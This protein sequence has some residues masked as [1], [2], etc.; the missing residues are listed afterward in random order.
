MKKTIIAGL[1]SLGAMNTAA[2]Q[3]QE[4]TYGADPTGRSPGSYVG[5]TETGITVLGIESGNTTNVNFIDTNADVT[6]EDALAKSEEFF[7]GFPWPNGYQA[8]LLANYP[9]LPDDADRFEHLGVTSTMEAGEFKKLADALIATVKSIIKGTTYL[10]DS[11]EASGYRAVSVGGNQV[12][13]ANGTQFD[14]TT[15]YSCDF[16]QWDTS[17]GFLDNLNTCPSSEF[18]PLNVRG[19]SA[20]DIGLVT[21]ASNSRGT[22]V[23]KAKR[24]ESDTNFNEVVVFNAESKTFNNYPINRS[25]VRNGSKIQI[26]DGQKQFVVINHPEQSSGGFYWIDEGINPVEFRGDSNG[27]KVLSIDDDYINMISEN[28]ELFTCENNIQD[29]S[30]FTYH[31]IVRLELDPNEPGYEFYAAYPSLPAGLDGHIENLGIQDQL[32]LGSGL[33]EYKAFIEQHIL[34][35]VER[36]LQEYRDNKMIFVS[37]GENT[38][39]KIASDVSGVV[40]TFTSGG[41]QY[42]VYVKN[43][44]KPGEDITT[45]NQAVAIAYNHTTESSLSLSYQMMKELEN[46]DFSSLI[47]V[48]KQSNQSAYGSLINT[49]PNMPDNF[50]DYGLGPDISKEEYLSFV[51]NVVTNSLPYKASGSVDMYR[52]PLAFKFNGGKLGFNAGFL[53]LSETSENSVTVTGKPA[54]AVIDPYT[55]AVSSMDII[56]DGELFAADV[57]CSVTGPLDITS[58]EYGSWG[59]SERLTLPV[60]WQNKNASGVVSL[61]GDIDSVTGEQQLLVLDTLAELTTADVTVNCSATV[62]DKNG[63]QLSVNLVPVTIRLDDGIHGGS[64]V[65]TGQVTL[66]A[67]VNAEDVTVEVTI[68]GRTINVEV[69]ENGRFEFD[70]LRDGDFT[71]NVKSERYTQSCINTT[72]GGNTIDLGNIEL[73]A[74][75]VNNDGEINIA[76]FTYLAGRYGSAKG[77]ERY[78]VQADLNSD[79]KVNIQDLAILGSHFGSRQC[80]P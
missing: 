25:F 56:T 44:T 40:E 80:N 23:L 37:C 62:S 48:A 46:S 43:V 55:N 67:G 47:E 4:L 31:D 72:T 13:I 8:G 12:L 64:G 68:N 52:L 65:I 42:T 69:D 7:R 17:K 73:I 10:Y 66:P 28:K 2:L 20:F 79:D 50:E 41:N 54:D 35:E 70:E 26:S 16:S 78:T 36:L 33:A 77:D 45:L 32:P 14:A 9:A 30:K 1:L 18:D 27:N 38:T 57:S 3:Y 11:S 53:T 61:K 15:V 63:S 71:V 60:Q 22:A 6:L 29:P 75:D 19:L 76:D 21:E 59:G 5:T 49:L 51:A 24:S 34:P 39:Q 58:A 74:G